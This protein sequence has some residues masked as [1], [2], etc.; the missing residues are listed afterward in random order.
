[1]LKKKDLGGMTL[2]VKFM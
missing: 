2:R 1:M